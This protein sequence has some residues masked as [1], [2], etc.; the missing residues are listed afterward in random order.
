MMYGDGEKM[1]WDPAINPDAFSAVITIDVS[2]CV[3]NLSGEFI[4]TMLLLREQS[5][6][7]LNPSRARL[8]TLFG[9]TKRIYLFPATFF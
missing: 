9:G 6:P 8:M 4:P 7:H 5:G 1:G 3:C 2:V